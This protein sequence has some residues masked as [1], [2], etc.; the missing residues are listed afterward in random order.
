MES[1]F[2]CDKILFS[3]IYELESRRS[4]RDCWPSTYFYQIKIDT[5]PENQ[6]SIKEAGQ[7]LLDILSSEISCCDVLCQLNHDQYALILY[8]VDSREADR[9]KDRISNHYK[10]TASKLEAKLE[11]DCKSL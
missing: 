3:H 1:A 11:I 7:H 5:Y 10:Q 6:P 9:I 8:D 2:I 4:E